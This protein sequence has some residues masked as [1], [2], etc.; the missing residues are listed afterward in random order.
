MRRRAA[1]AIQAASHFYYPDVDAAGRP[2]YRKEG[3]IS[4]RNTK[5]PAVT[6]Y[7]LDPFAAVELGSGEARR[8]VSLWLADGHRPEPVD[9][10][11]H[12]AGAVV[13]RLYAAD[14][15]ARAVALPETTV[16]LFAE[17]G[18]PDAAWADEQGGVVAVRHG[19]ARL[20]LAL[21][22]RRGF[23]RG[24]R[25]LAHVRVNNV[26]RAHFTTPTVDRIAT[27]RMDSPHGF[28]KLYVCRY[29][30]Y[31]IGMNLTADTAYTLPATPGAGSAI[32]LVSGQRVDAGRPV[33]VPPSTTVVLALPQ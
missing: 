17:P 6:D 3:I 5:W 4:T 22:W 16:R 32:D 2:L 9:E 28:G 14:S 26:A 10:G 1:Q 33:P 21:N 25:D 31:L 23:S 11:A 7:G 30:P 18:Q 13:H 12:F 24:G 8:A 19:D 15:L 29:G 20:Y 27:L